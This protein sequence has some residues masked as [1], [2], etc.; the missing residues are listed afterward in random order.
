MV[1]VVVPIYNIEKILS[2]CIDS[3]INQTYKD[4]EII[5][6]DDES[7]DNSSA[8]CYEY[9]KHDARINMINKQNG[10]LSDARNAGL[11]VANGEWIVFV[12]GDDWLESDYIERLLSAAQNNDAD[13]AICSFKYVYPDGRLQPVLTNEDQKIMSNRQ[14][15][16]DLLTYQQYGKVMTWN[17]IYKTKLFQKHQICFPKGKIHEDN[18][19]TYKTYFYAKKIVYINQPLYNYFQRDN[20]I[21]AEKFSEKRLDAVEAA[22]Q[23]LDFIRRKMPEIVDAAEYNLMMSYITLL[24]RLH[25]SNSVIKYKKIWSKAMQD[26]HFLN[27][28]ITNNQYLRFKDRLRLK[29]SFFPGLYRIMDETFIKIK[30][31]VG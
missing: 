22:K 2:R 9:A 5:L 3:I 25:A 6:V 31:R 17:K 26:L 13:I 19:T 29:L 10:G 30:K 1:S 28:N 12:D 11:K 15:L 21:M 14:A 27:S 23:S 7:P 24:N 8:I 18:F 4:L 20:S 16:I